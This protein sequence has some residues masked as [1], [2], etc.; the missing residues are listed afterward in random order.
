MDDQQRQ[1]KNSI[2]LA[3]VLGAIVLAWY[4]LAMFVVI[5]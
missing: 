4:V 2:K 1:H 5:R 3:L